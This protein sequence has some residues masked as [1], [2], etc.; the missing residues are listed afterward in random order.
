MA[1]E[2]L[3]YRFIGFL[4]SALQKPGRWQPLLTGLEVVGIKRHG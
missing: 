2:E 3:E 4:L 1:D